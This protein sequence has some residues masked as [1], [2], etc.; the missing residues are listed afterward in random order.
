MIPLPTLAICL[1][2]ALSA[3]L[4]AWAWR[5]W[6]LLQRSRAVPSAPEGLEEER[7]ELTAL[8]R[9]HAHGR[10]QRRLLEGRVAEAEREVAALAYSI[11]HDLRAPLR[12]IDGF[13]QALT[14]DYGHGLDSTAQDY[15]RRVRGNVAQ[16]RTLI[17][18]MLVLS[19]VAT[20]PFRV[21]RVDVSALAREIAAELTAAESTRL[22]RWEIPANIV[23]VGDRAL[24]AEA[25]RQLLGNAWKFTSARDVA[26]VSLRTVP[27]EQSGL[28][29]IVYEVRDNGAG[30][31]MQYAGKLFGAFQRMHPPEEFPGGR[32]IG[33]AL[34][35][36]IVRRHGGQVWVEA[37]PGQGASFSFTLGGPGTVPDPEDVR[38]THTLVAPPLV[39]GAPDPSLS[40]TTTV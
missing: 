2:S 3:T 23:A 14:E 6:K 21:E 15:L 38:A 26:Q 39:D 30:F 12:A 25:L 11:S 24:L 8:R 22:I 4:L 40:T 36:R 17:D 31:D 19:R 10:E 29:S 1:L 33:L 9:A 37:T 18:D 34:V 35:Q 20:A 28:A 32:G 27:T 7:R 5:L 13:S 16:M